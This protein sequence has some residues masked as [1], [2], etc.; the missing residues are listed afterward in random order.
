MTYKTGPLTQ[1]QIDGFVAAVQAKHDAHM[2]KNYPTIAVPHREIFSA[3]LG[4]KY[5]KIVR[6]GSN[7]TGGSV[8]C[9]L[10]RATGYIL[11]AASWRAPA[12][13]AR[14]TVHT[15]TFGIEYMSD[16]GARYLR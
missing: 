8:H 9:F 10:E 1:A 14:G 4:P 15:P 2:Q 11:K 16:Y 7:G 3:R 5:V 6:R 12:K 13:H